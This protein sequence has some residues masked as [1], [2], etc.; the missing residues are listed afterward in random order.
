MMFQS[1]PLWYHLPPTKLSV[2][3]SPGSRPKASRPWQT[4]VGATQ[5]TPGR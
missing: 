4:T 5:P 2:G 1:S 3:V